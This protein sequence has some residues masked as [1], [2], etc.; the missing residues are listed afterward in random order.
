MPL[1]FNS[2][3]AGV[4]R[5]MAVLFFLCLALAG[6]SSLI[7]LMEMPIHILTDFGSESPPTHSLRLFVANPP[8]SQFAV[9]LPLSS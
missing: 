3:D 4:G 5:F 1:L 6:L 8:P 2:I 9:S 7:S